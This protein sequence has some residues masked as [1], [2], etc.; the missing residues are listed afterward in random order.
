MSLLASLHSISPMAPVLP[1][2]V[3][4]QIAHY[5]CWGPESHSSTLFQP[6]KLGFSSQLALSS[7]AYRKIYLGRWFRSL[8]LRSEGDWNYAQEIGIVGYVKI[9][10]IAAGALL[11]D[12]SIVDRFNLSSFPSIQT[13]FLDCHNDVEC[14]K[15]SE[16]MQWSYKK[17]IPRLPPS[18]KSLVIL[19]A[20]GP[21]TQVVRQARA[22]CPGLE[23][24]RLGRC[25]M[26]NQPGHCDFWQAF[27]HDHDAYFSSEGVEEY[28]KALGKE[29]ASL[30]RLKTLRLGI[31]L[32]NSKYLNTG[33]PGSPNPS[34]MDPMMH[35]TPTAPPSGKQAHVLVNQ[36]NAAFVPV[37]M[38]PDIPIPLTSS[39]FQDR[40]DTFD[41]ETSAAAILF[42]CHKG[43]ESVGF[44][45]YWSDDHLGWN[46]HQPK[47]KGSTT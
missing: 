40:K 26:F 20:H 13:L 42:D 33:Q 25:T 28:A 30:R 45:S 19:N 5:V 36:P 41:L 11:L 10:S 35:T 47:A 1:L 39:R 22:Q 43:L 21:E 23:H 32:T 7:K 46:I 27:P 37:S 3:I 2:E 34:P 6:V 44:N 12:T 14:S 8:I 31:Y 4:Q 16:Q 15:S 18:L 38:P 17:I 29:L 24:L 9:L